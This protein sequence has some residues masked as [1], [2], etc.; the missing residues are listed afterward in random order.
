MSGES[1]TASIRRTVLRSPLDFGMATPLRAIQPVNCPSSTLFQGI[2]LASWYAT[3]RLRPLLAYI[4]RVIP[5]T[6]PGLP[7][8]T[9]SAFGQ[10]GFL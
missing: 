6:R 10:Y 5:G 8:L 3:L 2:V 9:A 1:K 4:R 7:F